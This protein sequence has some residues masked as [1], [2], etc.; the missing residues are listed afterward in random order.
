MPDTLQ[1]AC[2]T[3]CKTGDRFA[4]V[5]LTGANYALERDT[6][7][8]L[9]LSHFPKHSPVRQ[10]VQLERDDNE[11]CEEFL[12]AGGHAA[13]RVTCA[14]SDDSVPTYTTLSTFQRGC[15]CVTASEKVVAAGGDDFKIVVKEH[16]PTLGTEKAEFELP[17][18][19]SS[20]AIEPLDEDYLVATATDGKIRVFSV[21]EKQEIK[22]LS[23]R[24]PGIVVK[25]FPNKNK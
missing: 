22:G 14:D 6:Q 1:S 10:I 23:F 8:P 2:V 17:C 15:T 5:H 11:E 21:D 18:P 24:K 4:L 13:V 20:L 16:S 19:V 25:F 7:H 9:A 12:V 3:S